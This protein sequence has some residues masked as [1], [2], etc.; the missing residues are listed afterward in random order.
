[1]RHF[2]RIILA[3]ASALS[4]LL[5]IADISLWLRSHRQ[6][7]TISQVIGGSRYRMISAA[8]VIR[9]YGPPPPSADPRVRKSVDEVVASLN[10][11][12]IHWVGFYNPGRPAMNQQT[13][14]NVEVPRAL[15]NTPAERAEKE[16][17][18][19]DLARSLLA[20][21]EDPQR[22]TVAHM[23][24]YRPSSRSNEVRSRPIPGRYLGKRVWFEQIV[25]PDSAPWVEIDLFGLR[26][27]LNR[28]RYPDVF[29]PEGAIPGQ[30][31]MHDLVGQPDVNQLS[32]IR[33]MWHRSL[34][35]NITT[36]HHRTIAAATVLLPLWS[37][38]RFT[39]NKVVRR[40]RRQLGRCIV[41]GYDL[42]ASPTRCP[43][44]GTEQAKSLISEQS[45]PTESN[46]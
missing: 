5:C 46:H 10:N 38:V 15:P 19:A 18:R 3:A 42:R 17:T 7:E 41:C 2:L 36:V 40:R 35:V 20:A 44:C 22:L 4:L 25:V 27:T 14:I 30:A 33:D 29:V 9:L 34:D 32:T 1:M 16:F 12:Q 31:W 21:L 24:L 23:L 26:V 28:W 43:E 37:L 11:D 13:T 45:N 8:G 6:P 39:R